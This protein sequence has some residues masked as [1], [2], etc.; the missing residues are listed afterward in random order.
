MT[1]NVVSLYVLVEKERIIR[2]TALLLE[3]SALSVHL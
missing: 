2:K 1:R 3:V